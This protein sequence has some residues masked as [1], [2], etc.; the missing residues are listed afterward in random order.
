MCT[1]RQLRT[2]IRAGCL[3]AMA[4]LAADA[5]AAAAVAGPAAGQ[6]ASG[7]IPKAVLNG[8]LAGCEEI[9]FAQRVSGR[10]HWYGNFGHYCE[11]DSPSSNA[12]LIKEGEM[13][14]AFGHGGRLCRL[15]L[16]RHT[17]EPREGFAHPYNQS[18]TRSPGT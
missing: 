9:V 1:K 17:V 15:N 14:Y 4:I 6:A 18:S 2:S 5:H 8:P 16:R 3:C 13:G 11:T 12:A 7:A 10:D